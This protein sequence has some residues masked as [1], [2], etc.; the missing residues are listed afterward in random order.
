MPS[1]I[2]WRNF[3]CDDGSGFEDETIDWLKDRDASVWHQCAA[4]LNWDWG[5][6]IQG[7]IVSQQSC[8]V[9]TAAMLFWLCQ[10]QELIDPDM[11]EL[12][13][14]D[15]GSAYYLARLIAENCSENW[16]PKTQYPV[17]ENSDFDFIFRRYSELLL[18]HP[19][20]KEPWNT[21]LENIPKLIVH[22]QSELLSNEDFIEGIPKSIYGDGV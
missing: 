18:K 22:N 11:N 16:Y 8:S 3:S 4:D 7:W 5:W 15:S 17:L 19:N 2:D 14:A 10:P 9:S 13:T 6:R 1:K 12:E 20:L 21:M